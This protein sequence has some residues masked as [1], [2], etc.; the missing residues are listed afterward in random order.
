MQN[1]RLRMQ[2]VWNHQVWSPTSGPISRGVSQGSVR[3][4]FLSLSTV[5]SLWFS[6]LRNQATSQTNRCYTNKTIFDAIS[7]CSQVIFTI[8][9]IQ[10]VCTRA[11][12]ED[13]WPK[14]K[15]SKQRNAHFMTFRGTRAPS[16]NHS[17]RW[18]AERVFRSTDKR[19]GP[20]KGHNPLCRR[21]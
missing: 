4:P 21:P 7:T 5:H 14:W 15:Y 1:L 20:S 8:Y 9:L 13:N 11:R 2:G 12:T 6:Y 19:P 17:L 3:S 18:L 10:Y 16:M